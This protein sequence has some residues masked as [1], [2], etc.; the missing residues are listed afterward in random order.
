MQFRSIQDLE[1]RLLGQNIQF[2]CPSQKWEPERQQTLSTF[3][4]FTWYFPMKEE[5]FQ[6]HHWVDIKEKLI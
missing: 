5:C 3:F 6:F 2:F 1:G 4:G